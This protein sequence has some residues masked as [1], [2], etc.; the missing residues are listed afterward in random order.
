MRKKDFGFTIIEV[1]MVILTIGILASIAMPLF[2]NYR[3]RGFDRRAQVSL[4]NTAIAEEAYYVDFE[5][6]KECDQDSCSKIL[7]GL[8]K[9]SSGVKLT[10][11]TTGDGFSGEAT[12]PNGTGQVFTWDK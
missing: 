7:P 12:H 5:S 11:I 2:S 1:L 6:Y 3:G 9:L 10:M 4:R 8:G